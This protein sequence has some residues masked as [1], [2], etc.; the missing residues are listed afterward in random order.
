MLKNFP[1]ITADNFAGRNIKYGV[2]EFGM[3]TIANGLSQTGMFIPF[4]GTFLTFSDYMRNAIR[5][6]ALQ[7]IQVVYQF[8]HDSIFLGE[9]GPTHQPVE[10]YAALRAIPNLQV[11]RPGSAYEVQ[12]SWM[13]ALRYKG[14]TALLLTRQNLPE[15]AETKEFSYKDG[16]GRGAYILK[17]EKTKADYTLFATGSELS[18]AIDVA[19]ALEKKGKSVRVV[20]LPCF[21]LFDQQDK[22]YRESVVG[23]DI[24]KRVSIEAGVELGW[25][26]Y[27]GLDGVAISMHSFGASAPAQDLAK[28]FGF[29]VEAILEKI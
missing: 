8:T 1:L 14:P 10:H 23:G 2:R 26:K 27:I 28:E 19:N 18:L 12:M 13:A 21:E 5:L 17:K 24:G 11:I 7:K 15:I 22:A 9:D 25:Y 16:V 6:A 20:S 4:I 3:A 29:T